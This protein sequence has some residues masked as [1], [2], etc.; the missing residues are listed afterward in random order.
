MQ[1]IY[2]ANQSSQKEIKEADST[3]RETGDERKVRLR[4]QTRELVKEVLGRVGEK[5][6]KDAGGAY[7][8]WPEGRFI[9]EQE[10]EEV[11]LLLRAHPITNL[12]WILMAILMAVFPE[13]LSLAGMFTGVPLRFMLAGRLFWYLA[14]FGFCFEKFLN[15]WYSVLIVTN[16]RVVD[17]DFVNLLYR[18]V[19][20]AT[21]NHIE[22]P[23]MVAGGFIRSL[24]R[25]GDIFV[26]TAAEAATVEGRGIPY[27][28]KVIKIIS[29][30][31]EELE[32]R[33]ERGE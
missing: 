10:D 3:S 24:F 30:L 2:K 7:N 29:E 23:S 5:P 18:V 27:P 20:Y 16:E 12:R 19:S 17:I 28:D 26:A 31:S 21:L 25:Y 6:R 14:I 15:W 11:V 9:N 33:R 1:E 32:K 8:V 13:L 22:E 4:D